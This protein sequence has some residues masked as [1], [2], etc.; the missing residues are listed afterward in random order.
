MHLNFH[1][2][3]SMIEMANQLGIPYRMNTKMTARDDLARDTFDL[4]I[5]KDDMKRQFNGN[6]EEFYEKRVDNDRLSDMGCVMG[7]SLMSIN[8]YGDVFPCITVPIPAGN[9]RYA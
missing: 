7:R 9:V 2:Y 6:F 1:E 5:A 3:D 8:A 4:S